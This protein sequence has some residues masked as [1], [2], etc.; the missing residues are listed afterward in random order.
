VLPKEKKRLA[1]LSDSELGVISKA[2][3]DLYARTAAVNRAGRTRLVGAT[4]AAKVLY[5]VRPNAVTAWD[6]AI[7][8]Q[9]GGGQ[10]EASFLAHLTTCRGWA[11]DLEEEGRALGLKSRE[12]GPHLGRPESSVAK[13]IDEWLYATVTRAIG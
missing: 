3:G 8:W 12:I 1:K 6:N 9:T 10:T 11:R 7:S 5:F 13:L 4:A 2:Y